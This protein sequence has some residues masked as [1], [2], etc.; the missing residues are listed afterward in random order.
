MQRKCSFGQR[1]AENYTVSI[2]SSM[3]IGHIHLKKVSCKN[4]KI[5]FPVRKKKYIME[6]LKYDTRLLI[7]QYCTAY[8]LKVH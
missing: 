7:F 2:D 5:F 8:A 4:K 1:S 3:K 6:A